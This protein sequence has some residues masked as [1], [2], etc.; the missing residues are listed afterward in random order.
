MHV[1]IQA[2]KGIRQATDVINLRLLFKPLGKIA[3][4]CNKLRVTDATRFIGIHSPI[5]R[6]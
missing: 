2:L 6:L 4:H 1:F 3:H 5:D